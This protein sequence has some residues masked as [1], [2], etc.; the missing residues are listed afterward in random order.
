[1]GYRKVS[2]RI[3]AL[4]CGSCVLPIKNHLYKHP[5]VRA[6]HVIG[7]RVVVE[8]DDKFSIMDILES[9]GV[10]KYYRVLEINELEEKELVQEE[11]GSSS[12]VFR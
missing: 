7:Y 4:G 1:L 3:E 9:T 5:G 11:R 12:Y 6:V 8:Y 2:L 10:L